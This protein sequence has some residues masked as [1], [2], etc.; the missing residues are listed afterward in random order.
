MPT[1]KR[2][3]K[4]CE[5]WEHSG[6]ASYEP[7]FVFRCT[8]CGVAVCTDCGS[9]A[10]HEDSPGNCRR[11]AE[12]GGERYL[13]NTKIDHDLLRAKVGR[14]LAAEILSECRYE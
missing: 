12:K 6:E 2:S 3:P 14:K 8:R 9:C 10:V 7:E 11:C 5:E 1:K 4:R 13:F